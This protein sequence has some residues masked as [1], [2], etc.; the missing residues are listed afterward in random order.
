MINVAILQGSG[1]TGLAL[2]ELLL[3]HPQV[4]LRALTSRSQAGLALGVVEPRLAGRNAP[5]F[6]APDA[7]DH[8]SIDCVFVCAEHGH[9]AQ[10]VAA[11]LAQGFAGSVIDLSSDFRL[12]DANAYPRWY[13]RAHEQPQLL[14]RFIYGL[15]D[16]LPAS[17]RSGF[18]ANP[19]CFATAITLALLP[20]ARAGLLTHA[21]VTAITGATGSGVKPAAATHYPLRDGNLR[22]YK[23]HTH[24]HQGEILQ[25]LG[26]PL[27]LDFVPVSGPFSR[28][29]WG[30]ASLRLSRSLGEAECA[31]LFRGFYADRALV[32]LHPKRL[33]EL[34]DAVHTPFA[35]IGWIGGG[36]QLL[37]GFALD[38]LLKGAASQALQNFNRVF[39]LDDTM[40][41]L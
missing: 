19:G 22:A 39:G 33:P 8:K 25:S 36:E 10:M 12:R 6:I 38:N 27:G 15:A 24:Q 40:G 29:I 31:D 34:R 9:A 23:V 35:D 30:T 32:R 28:G 2:V 13:D 4:R 18:V 14:D 20:L 5:P 41:L 1:Y 7:L 26:V 17:E 37:L 3:R 16:V 21:A 11:L